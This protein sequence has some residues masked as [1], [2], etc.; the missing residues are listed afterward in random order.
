L[1][2][3]NNKQHSIS[4]GIIQ[5]LL[6]YFS[7]QQEVCESLIVGVIGASRMYN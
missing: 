5:E 4:G 2:F 1:E 3:D 6:E 7:K